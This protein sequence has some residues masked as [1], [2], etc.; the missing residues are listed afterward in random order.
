MFEVWLDGTWDIVDT[1]GLAPP[2]T[3]VCIV[4]GRDATDIALMTGSAT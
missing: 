1:I 4:G 3:I 2:E